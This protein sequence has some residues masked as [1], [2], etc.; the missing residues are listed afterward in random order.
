[1]RRSIPRR[2]GQPAQAGFSRTGSYRKRGS[3]RERSGQESHPRNSLISRISGAPT[4]HD[5]LNDWGCARPGQEGT[6]P[7]GAFLLRAP[8]RDGIPSFRGSSAVEQPAVN[9]L[10]VGSNPTRGAICCRARASRAC[11][12]PSS[13]RPVLRCSE[14]RNRAPAPTNALRLLADN[15]IH[16]TRRRT[17]SSIEPSRVARARRVSRA[18]L[19]ISRNIRSTRLQ[20]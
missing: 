8:P 11:A 13:P 15:H 17:L 20:R 4:I 14:G 3:D 5:I 10:V 16:G 19:A 7:P 12:P 18:L 9:R 6:S 2:F 1:M